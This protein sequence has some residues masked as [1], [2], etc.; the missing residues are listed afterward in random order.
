MGSGPPVRR[1]REGVRKHQGR[2]VEKFDEPVPLSSDH[3]PNRA[4]EIESS[5]EA[6]N[7]NIAA[8]ICN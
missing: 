4:R 7:T 6:E 3:A 5:A 8:S 2:T 1:D